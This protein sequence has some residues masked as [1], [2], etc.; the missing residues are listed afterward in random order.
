VKLNFT[1]VY[2]AKELLESIK[3]VERGNM[4]PGGEILKG[5]L[6]SGEARLV[7]IILLVLLVV[8]FLSRRKSPTLPKYQ[9]Q[10]DDLRNLKD[11]LDR[12]EIQPIQKPVRPESAC[13][14]C[15]RVA[16][17]QSKRVWV[18]F[19]LKSAWAWLPKGGSIFRGNAY[20]V[21][22]CATCVDENDWY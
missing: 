2:S 5:I 13:M 18:P 19:Y 15:G 16:S 12:T 1:Y 9:E 11:M 14:K 4:M 21:E 17:L 6:E 8:W 3:L 20:N 7:C 22:V 10:P